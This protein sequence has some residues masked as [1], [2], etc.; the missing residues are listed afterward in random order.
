MEVIQVL[1]E[2]NA[3]MA[4]YTVNGVTATLKMNH[5][6]RA[7]WI[8]DRIRRVRE[9]AGAIKIQGTAPNLVEYTAEPVAEGQEWKSPFR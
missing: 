7:C 8:R 4:R 2:E 6:R 5:A 3:C 9:I 1:L